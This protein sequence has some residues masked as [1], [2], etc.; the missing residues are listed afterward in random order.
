MYCTL[1]FYAHKS[2]NFLTGPSKKLKFGYSILEW[3]ILGIHDYCATC[4]NFIYL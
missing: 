1:Y 4:Y 2:G 3:Q